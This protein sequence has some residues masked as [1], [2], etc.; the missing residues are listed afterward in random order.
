LLGA[1]TE[2][3][4]E[5]VDARSAPKAEGGLE[6]ENFRVFERIG[7]GG[8]AEVFRARQLEPIEREVALKLIRVGMSSERILARFEA[9]RQVLARLQHPYIATVLD[10]GHT[11]EGR[12]YFALEFVDGKPISEF[13]EDGDLSLSDRLELFVKVCK[14]VHHAHQRGIVHRDLKPSNILVGSDGEPKVIDFGIARALEEE[15]DAKTL[16]LTRE[17]DFLG[18]PA[19]M[20]PEQARGEVAEIDTR[21]D[22]YA[23]GVVLYELLTG[24]LPVETADVRAFSSGSEKSIERPSRRDTT[25]RVNASVMRGDIDWIVMRSLEA[26]KERRYDSAAAFGDDI[27]RY[28]R[29]EPVSAG[30]PT[31][32]Y[33][34]KKFT[35]RHRGIAAGVSI[36]A[37]SLVAGT[38]VSVWQAGRANEAAESAERARQVALE[39]KEVALTVNYFLVDD[40][41]GAADAE[42]MSEPDLRVLE[43]VD[44]AAVKVDERFIGKPKA[45]GL[46]NEAIGNVYLALGRYES[47][48]DRLSR[49]RAAFESLPESEDQ[50]F[51]LRRV[52]RELSTVRFRQRRIDEARA[53]YE[54]AMVVSN[55]D[56]VPDEA[57]LSGKMYL[58]GLVKAEGD[59]PQALEILREVE[60]EL[61]SRPQSDGLAR[62]VDYNIGL[63]LASAG[64]HAEAI[65]H[66]ERFVAWL[67]DEPTAGLAES[68]TEMA[69][70]KHLCGSSAEAEAD[71]LRAVEIQKK[72]RPPGHPSRTLTDESLASLYDDTG[73][74]ED[75]IPIYERLLAE[76]IEPGVTPHNHTIVAMHN[77]AVAI[78]GTDNNRASELLEGAIAGRAQLFGDHHPTTAS[79]RSSLAFVRWAE[80]DFDAAIALWIRVRDDYKAAL[81]ASHP[82]VL[83]TTRRL[84]LGEFLRGRPTDALHHCHELLST[85]APEAAVLVPGAAMQ[86]ENTYQLVGQN[87]TD[88]TLLFELGK[89][90]VEA[91]PEDLPAWSMLGRASYAI[92]LETGSAANLRIGA[93]ASMAGG[94]VRSPGIA[95]FCQAED[96]P[97]PR[98]VIDLNKPWRYAMPTPVGDAWTEVG[99]DDSAWAVGLPE[100]GYGDGDEVTVLD[101]GADP[102]AKPMS[103]AFRTVFEFD[104]SQSGALAVDL[105]CDD[106]AVV[107]LDGREVQRVRMPE[108]EISPE[109]AAKVPLGGFDEKDAEYF[110]I[111]IEAFAPGSEHTL[112]VQVHQE[113]PS[114]SDLSFSLVALVG[115]VEFSTVRDRV[116]DSELE[117]FFGDNSAAEWLEIR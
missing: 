11:T 22:V 19:Y 81:G 52:L 29:N 102:N 14:A 105:V 94:D 6:V 85:P 114:S 92:Y 59:L 100:L 7:E 72:V 101:Y 82:E 51:H 28:L 62:K 110:V 17:G 16:F 32:I 12:P 56:S 3:C 55:L 5:E 97:E 117:S 47:A 42:G 58:S 8:T 64:Q 46:V 87:V 30:P 38:C 73:R 44:R 80:E 69:K 67:G 13:A 95:A 103:A 77:Y 68:L 104:P 61:A 86:R 89:V 112:A 31:A 45:G 70:A 96:I 88:P 23:L 1:L 116:S 10:A 83:T 108:G 34:L 35:K 49:S 93:L 20:S 4:G 106:G 40:L 21:T 43:L 113:Q 84:A 50:R 27:G 63:A 115:L 65:P 24:K 25:T 57:R 2:S 99:F 37:L 41:L 48:F 15:L 36:G 107:Y 39:E 26:D 9:E 76:G 111:P 74:L 90:A 54:E 18:T 33:R 60:Q 71:L 53:L 75:A 91:H 98:M 109:T 66:Y 78:T 79:S